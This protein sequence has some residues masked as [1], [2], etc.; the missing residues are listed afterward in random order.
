LKTLSEIFT[1]STAESFSLSS[2][3]GFDVAELL[4]VLDDAD[5]PGGLVTAVVTGICE[6][7]GSNKWRLGIEKCCALVGKALLEDWAEQVAAKKAKV[8]SL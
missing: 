2:P 5:V 7:Q 4:R 1:S 8:G 3:A 6:Q